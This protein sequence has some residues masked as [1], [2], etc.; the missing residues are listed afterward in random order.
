MFI[1]I[2]ICT[3]KRKKNKRKKQKKKSITFEKQY[4]DTM[5]KKRINFK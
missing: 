4:K 2:Y 5:K 3:K 1:Y